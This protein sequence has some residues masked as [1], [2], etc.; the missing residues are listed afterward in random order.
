MR[1]FVAIDLPDEVKR[2][3]A[4]IC[5]GV[6]GV[7]W[8]PPDQ[9]H[10][11]LRFIGEEDDAVAAAIRRGLAEI[12]SPPFPLSLQGVGCFPSPRR[13]RVLWVGLSGGAPLQQLQQKV[14]AAVVAA[15]ILAEERPFSPHITLARLR[16]HREGDVAPFLARNASFH[17]EPFT[18]DAFHLYSSILAA[19][20]AIH[21]HEASYPLAGRMETAG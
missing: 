10:L 18:V 1:L 20:G 5:R 3:V 8:L 7:R 6:P 13:P 15:G 12:T 16:E 14:E 2:S 19:K 4:D 21:R 11:T 9:L 17:C